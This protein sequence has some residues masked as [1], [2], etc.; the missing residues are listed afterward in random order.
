MPETQ[1]THQAQNFVNLKPEPDPTYNS[2]SALTNRKLETYAATFS[3]NIYAQE[4]TVPH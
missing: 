1:A 3:S 2:A 4:P